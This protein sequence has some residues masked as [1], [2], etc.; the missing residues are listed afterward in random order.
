MGAINTNTGRPAT[1][2]ASLKVTQIHQ[3]PTGNWAVEAHDLSHDLSLA[4]C[5]WTHLSLLC[6]RTL[7]TV[8]ITHTAVSQMWKS[9]YK[10]LLYLSTTSDSVCHLTLGG[11]TFTSNLIM[12][13]VTW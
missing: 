3:V 1:K 9:Y 7:A 12:T 13:I 2:P 5:Q 6:T 11:A 4:V 8:P 10:F